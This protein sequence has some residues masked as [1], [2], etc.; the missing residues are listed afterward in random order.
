MTSPFQNVK[1]R[2]WD[3]FF[4]SFDRTLIIE[5]INR[6]TKQTIN[7]SID[8]IWT[9]RM[10]PNL[11]HFQGNYLII[12]AIIAASSIYSIS[13]QQSIFQLVQLLGILLLSIWAMSAAP[14]STIDLAIRNFWIAVQVFYVVICYQSTKRGVAAYLL[15]VLIILGHAVVKKPGVIDRAV[16]QTINQSRMEHTPFGYV[17]L[18]LDKILD[19]LIERAE[20]IETDQPLSQPTVKRRSSFLQKMKEKYRTL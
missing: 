14:A 16:D 7:Q 9:S 8:K 15:I 12:M 3:S 10:L 18:R 17:L 19:R 1:V 13:V 5:T 11:L 4:S 20:T 6:T 2:D